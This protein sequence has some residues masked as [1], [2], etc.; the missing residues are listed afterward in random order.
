MGNLGKQELFNFLDWAGERG[1]MKKATARSLKV[2]CKGVLEVLDEAEEADVSKISLTDVF[3][4]YENLNSFNTTPGT[5][6]AYRNRVNYAI[7]E[8][9]SFNQDKANWKPSGGQ[10]ASSSRSTN[11]GKKKSTLDKIGD[12][13]GEIDIPSLGGNG[14]QASKITHR[15]PL[16][17]DMVVSISGIPFDVTR[18]EMGRLTA[19]LSNLVANTGG[20]DNESSMPMLNPSTNGS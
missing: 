14:D 11:K 4:R 13:Q 20:G 5:L 6:K 3:Q 19:Y 17:R 2:A 8:F 18:L 9:L 7:N 16:R 12:E 1:Q 10:R 15:F